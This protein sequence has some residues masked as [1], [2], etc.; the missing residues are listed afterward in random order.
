[1][2]PPPRLTSLQGGRYELVKKLGEGGKGLVYR[3]R[4]KSLDRMVAVK[5]LK[6]EGFDEASYERFLREAQIAA[7][8]THPHIVAIHDM[9]QEEGRYFLIMELVDGPSLRGLLEA[10]PGSPL[11]LALS[12]RIAAETSDAL[13]YAHGKGVLHRDIKPENV[14]ITSDGA[15]KLMDF[16]L[17]RALDK[18]RITAV[19]TIVGTPA[20]IAPEVA[21]G[22]EADGR[23]D[24]YSLGVVLYEMLTGRPPF[25]GD[26]TLKLVYS[27][28][29]DPPT[30]PRRLRPEIPVAVESLVLRLLSKNPDDRPPSA[31]EVSKALRELERGVPTSGGSGTAATP[32]PS[33]ERLPQGSPTGTDVRRASPLVGRETEFGALKSVVDRTLALDGSFVVLTGEAGIGKSRLLEEL[34]G[35]ANNRGLVVLSARCTE[36]DSEVPFGP[37][38]VLLRSLI[39]RTPVQLLYKTLGANAS[40]V[41]K[42]VPELAEKAGPAPPPPAG[43]VEQERKRLL[44]GVGHFLLA[45]ASETPLLVLIDDLAYADAASLE[46]LELVARKAAGKPLSVVATARELLT[47]D[48]PA[49]HRLVLDLNRDRIGTTLAIRRLDAEGVRRLI[50]ESLGETVVSA[51]FRDLLFEKTGG[52]PFFVEELLRALAEEGAIFR[53]PDGWDRKP[54]AE[55][56]LP[57]TVRSVILQRLAHL[58]EETLNLLRVASVAGVEFS[59]ELLLKVSDLGEDRLLDLL[60]QGLK[61]RLLTER[62]LSAS[63]SV[64]AFADRQIRDVL[65]EEISIVRARRYHLKVG[66]ALESISGTRAGEHAAELAHHFLRGNDSKRALEYSVRAGDDSVRLYA[67]DEAMRQY[68]TA[69]DLLEAEPNDLLRGRLLGELAELSIGIGKVAA[70]QR[71]FEQSAAAFEEAGA[72]TEAARLLARLALF[73]FSALYDFDRSLATLEHAVSMLQGEPEGRELATLELGLA[74]QYLYAADIGRAEQLSSHALEVARRVGAPDVEALALVARTYLVPRTE[75]PRALELVR[76]AQD[77]AW[78]SGDWEALRSIAPLVGR[79]ARVTGDLASTRRTMQALMEEC[80]RRGRIGDLMDLQGQPY[81]WTLLLSGEFGEARKLA[82]ASFE[83]ARQNYPVPDAPNLAVLGFVWALQGEPERGI[84]TLREAIGKPKDRSRGMLTGEFLVLEGEVHLLQRN[85]DLAEARFRLAA[86]EAL[87]YASL[88]ASSWVRLRAVEHLV[89]LQFARR[90]VGDSVV[91]APEAREIAR[92]GGSAFQLGHGLR[93]EGLTLALQGETPGAISRLRESVGQ[94]DA[95]G[96]HYETARTLVFWAEVCERASDRTAASEPLHRALDLFSRFDSKLDVQQ[97]LA[98]QELLKA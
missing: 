52:N 88:A 2:D 71:Y 29:H 92:A 86:Q 16:G 33:G 43:S 41:T 13:R 25:P 24:L 50:G 85:L 63:R 89:E 62:N 72:R 18:P 3:G 28:I 77:A 30:P 84:A 80:R 58:D 48:R 38:V 21:L 82:E 36:R 95:M 59:F 93:A 65:Y 31:A 17:A 87:P 73:Q 10:H 83:F 94:F 26:D 1:M 8:L 81:A 70:A 96:C 44:D 53:T 60:E 12:L 42:L 61:A 15:T 40:Q 19:L 23:S 74:T 6:T 35:Y 55:I 67:R 27:H 7:R 90:S 22:K 76:E 78:K 79:F 4:D 56:R 97:V 54:T 39:E 47:E 66:L 51:E 57:P 69:L 75:T 46:L 91:L 34:R 98:F 45:V 14:M 20:Y 64:Y 32:A 37:W 9:G 5:I 11:E 49:F 68:R